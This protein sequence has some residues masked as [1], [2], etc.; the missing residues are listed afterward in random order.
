M[1]INGKVISFRHLKTD[2][3]YYADV[4]FE[5]TKEAWD[6]LHRFGNG[7]VYEDT[8]MVLELDDNA[9]ILK[10]NKQI[11]YEIGKLQKKIKE[12]ESKKVPNEEYIELKDFSKDFQLKCNVCGRKTHAKDLYNTIC[13][14]PQPNQ[15]ICKGTFQKI[16]DK[17]V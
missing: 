14:I 4:S 3:L 1:K 17:E 8:D 5:L 13:N 16:G 10:K 9:V 7:T 11:D 15:S 6:S 12:L 2:K